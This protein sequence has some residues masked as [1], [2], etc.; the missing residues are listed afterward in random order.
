MFV[1]FRVKQVAT[2]A[3]SVEVVPSLEFFDRECGGILEWRLLD[4]SQWYKK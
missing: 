3:A 4:Y 2:E 1:M